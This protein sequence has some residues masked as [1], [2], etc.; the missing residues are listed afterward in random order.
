MNWTSLC[1]FYLARR[2][3]L[4][5]GFSFMKI[6]KNGLMF[7]VLLW[8]IAHFFLGPT[9]FT[10][11]AWLRLMF[12]WG[13]IPF[14][15]T[16]AWTAAPSKRKLKTGAHPQAVSKTYDRLDILRMG[17]LPIVIVPCEVSQKLIKRNAPRVVLYTV[18]THSKCPINSI[19]FY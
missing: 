18:P 5:S 19:Y 6:A 3:Q 12:I 7:F 10:I 9:F 15:S 14:P 13:C 16:M 8:E 4:V 2:A 1:S 17:P 11:P